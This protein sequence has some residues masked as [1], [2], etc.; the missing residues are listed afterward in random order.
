MNDRNR[1][2]VFYRNRALGEHRLD[3][4]VAQKVVV[5]L[6]AIQALDKIHFSIVRSYLKAT[7]LQSGLLIN[8]A[9]MPLTVK[10]VGREDMARSKVIS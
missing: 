5:E 1:F 8:F 10:R 7:K 6:K 2:Q 9:T 3:F 4:L